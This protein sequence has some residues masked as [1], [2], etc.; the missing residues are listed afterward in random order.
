MDNRFTKK[1]D[2]YI[3]LS[4]LLSLETTLSII[5]EGLYFL[6]RRRSGLMKVGGFTVGVLLELDISQDISISPITQDILPLTCLAGC[7]HMV[8]KNCA[9]SRIDSLVSV[10]KYH[11]NELVI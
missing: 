8:W 2:S 1:N 3:S 5:G 9:G 10:D 4:K 6:M 11:N 7:S